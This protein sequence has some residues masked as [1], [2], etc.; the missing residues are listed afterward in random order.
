[1]R[2]PFSE[3]ISIEG[4]KSSDINSSNTEVKIVP[5]IDP[6]SGD[7]V[8]L[9]KYNLTWNVT[10]LTEEELEIQLDFLDPDSISRYKIYD[11]I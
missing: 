8:D 5:Y 2:I 11:Q 9:S 4:I 1:V 3:K 7:L 6:S 10:Q